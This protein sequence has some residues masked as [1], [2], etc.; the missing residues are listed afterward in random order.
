[1]STMPWESQAER[2][3][4][5][6]SCSLAAIARNGRA[7]HTVPNR[8]LALCGQDPSGNALVVAI[9]SSRRNQP[10]Q[11][12]L[13]TRTACCI[14]VADSTSRVA[15]PV[16]NTSSPADSRRVIA[17]RHWCHHGGP[18]HR[19]LFHAV[20]TGPQHCCSDSGPDCLRQACRLCQHR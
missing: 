1:V 9:G 15:G 19:R 4:H 17:S 11:R 8:R 12:G 6:T 10:Q 7:R 16:A 5:P 20:R 13:R 2:A 3:T 18:G 14:A